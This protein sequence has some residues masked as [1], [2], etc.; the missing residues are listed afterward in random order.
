MGVTAGVELYGWAACLGILQDSVN[1]SKA[2]V[3]RLRDT[4]AHS[5]DPKERIEA[6][7]KLA[8]IADAEKI[9]QEARAA[10]VARLDD[11]RFVAG[12]GSNGGEEFLSYMMIAESLVVNGGDDWSRWDSRMTEN[13][14]RVQNGDG[15]WSG[16][17]CITG[18]TFCTSTA[19]LVLMADRTPVPV[20]EG[21]GPGVRPEVNPAARSRRTRP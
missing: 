1:T 7:Q 9:Q 8:R 13:L 2:E 15:S 16:S 19:L 6:E 14:E 3:P 18:R 12:V 10:V 17:H 21:R 4:A 5:E 20:Q 11:P